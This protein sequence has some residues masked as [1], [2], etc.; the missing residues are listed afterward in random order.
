MLIIKLGLRNLTRHKKRTVITGIVISLAIFIYLITDSLMFGLEELSFN[1]IINLESG[2]LQIAHSEYWEDR[3]ELPLDNLMEVDSQL[4]EEIRN[5]EG[6]TALAEM[7][8]FSARLN[9]GSDELPITGVGL[10]PS[11]Y[12]EVFTTDNYFIEGSFFNEDNYQGVMGQ[13]LAELMDLEIGDYFTLLTRTVGGTFNTI[14]VEISGLLKTPNPDINSNMVMLPLGLVQKSLNMENQITQVAVHL[15]IDKDKVPTLLQDLNQNLRRENLQV[16]GFSWKD[17]A[18]E[19][20]A[21]SEVQSVETF[22]ILGIILLIAAVGI[23][24]T[25]ILA[26][27]E[28]MEELGMM[29]AL[30]LKESEIVYTFMVEAAGVGI[31]GGLIGWIL[32]AGGVYYLTNVGIAFSD[33]VGDEI[34]FGMPIIDKIYGS[35]NIPAFIFI[36]V[37]GV[38]VAVLSS[39]LPAYWAARKDPIKA[40]YH[41]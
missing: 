16:Q 26:A 20:L 33:L 14:D 11:E 25:T 12:T 41:R 28:R 35:W 40:I 5:L 8:R 1:N 18:A 19:V 34:T 24:N 2:H 22:T 6:F 21:M 36:F 15:D 27:L 29:K 38:L 31:I 23:I 10:N 17:S 7:T 4:E 39:I 30:G 13:N 37:F 3:D 9:N 32:G